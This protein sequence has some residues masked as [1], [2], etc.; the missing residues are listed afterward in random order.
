MAKG[1]KTQHGALREAFGLP[2]FG[3]VY[4]SIS[5]VMELYQGLCWSVPGYN[6]T[7]L[8]MEATQSFAMVWKPEDRHLINTCHKSLNICISTF[9]PQFMIGGGVGR[10]VCTKNWASNQ[11]HFVTIH[12]AH[13]TATQAGHT[14]TACLQISPGTLWQYVLSHQTCSSRASYI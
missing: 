13:C 3:E 6:S 2:Y 14:H 12:R 9:H 11:C 10:P 1:T 4:T 5:R 7:N 8:Q